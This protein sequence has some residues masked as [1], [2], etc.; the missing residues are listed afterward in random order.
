MSAFFDVACLELR[1]M[2]CCHHIY[3]TVKGV[4]FYFSQMFETQYFRYQNLSII[5]RVKC[6]D[7]SKKKS[8][9]D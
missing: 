2:L 6:F 5:N 1:K 8:L 3:Y 4:F 9:W 7:L